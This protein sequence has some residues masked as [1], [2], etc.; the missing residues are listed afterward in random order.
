[1]AL[2]ALEI[3]ICII[4]LFCGLKSSFDSIFGS[5]GENE[6]VENHYIQQ[7]PISHSNTEVSLTQNMVSGQ[8]YLD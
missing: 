7:T 4:N 5:R 8:N 1:M 3:R 6:R 2:Q